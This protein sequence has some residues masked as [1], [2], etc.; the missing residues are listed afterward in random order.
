MITHTPGPWE[1]R[2]PKFDSLIL[3]AAER[4]IASVSFSDHADKECEANAH[5][6]AAA[7]ELLA[8]LQRI[9]DEADPCGCEHDD[10]HCCALK[11]DYCCPMCIAAVALKKV[12]T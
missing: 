7:P 11:A 10:D 4:V 12:R 3:D 1:A 2:W 5:L 6:I 9:A 8:A